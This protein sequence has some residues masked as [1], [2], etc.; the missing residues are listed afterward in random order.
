MKELHEQVRKT[1]QN[2][3]E[4]YKTRAEKIRRGLQFKLGDLVLPPNLV[5]SPIFNVCDLFSYRGTHIGTDQRTLANL[6]GVDWVLDLP[7]PQPL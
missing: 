6:E 2:Q 5:I 1:L 3:V 4:K 7:T